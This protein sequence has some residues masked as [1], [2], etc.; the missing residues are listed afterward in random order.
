MNS[1]VIEELRKITR[2]GVHFG[3]GYVFAKP[4]FPPL[5]ILRE[6]IV[7]IEKNKHLKWYFS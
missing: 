6:S 2:L 5:E 3:Q 7:C 4:Q 1:K